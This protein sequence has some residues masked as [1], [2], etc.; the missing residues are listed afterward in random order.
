MFAIAFSSPSKSRTLVSAQKWGPLQGWPFHDG[1]GQ[2]D[3]PGAKWA[4]ILLLFSAVSFGTISERSKISLSWQCPCPHVWVA[5]A[6]AVGQ[7]PA[8]DRANEWQSG[9]TGKDKQL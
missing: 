4:M 2:L 8:T 3:S 5:S 6:R 7:V 1:V 9:K